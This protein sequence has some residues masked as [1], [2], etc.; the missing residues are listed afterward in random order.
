MFA[1]E[2]PEFNFEKP[3]SGPR[4]YSQMLYCNFDN[5]IN[6]NGDVKISIDEKF[7]C[8]KDHMHNCQ[9]LSKNRMAVLF[10]SGKV[11]IRETFDTSFNTMSHK[12]NI[13]IRTPKNLRDQFEETTEDSTFDISDNGK[14]DFYY[15]QKN[16]ENIF[17]KT[18]RLF[19]LVL[20]TEQLVAVWSL[21]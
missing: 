8:D 7:Y 13:I 9:I 2:D 18:F 21:Y 3:T 19:G 20:V 10:R 12:D 14:A 1:F 16:I 15:F 6:D 4:H 11:A 5:F 17:Y